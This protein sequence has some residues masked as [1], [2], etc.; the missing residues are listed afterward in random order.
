MRKMIL[1]M[2]ALKMLAELCILIRDI[3]RPQYA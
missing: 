3:F 2:T 1:I